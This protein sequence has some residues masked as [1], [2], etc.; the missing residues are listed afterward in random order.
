[1]HINF[2]QEWDIIRYNIR[3][4]SIWYALTAKVILNNVI[5]LMGL[6]ALRLFRLYTDIILIISF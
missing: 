5:K 6:V 2:H 1:M 3:S 4:T